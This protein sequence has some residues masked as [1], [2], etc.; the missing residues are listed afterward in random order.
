MLYSNLELKA[1]NT[2]AYFTN[3]INDL[4]RAIMRYLNLK[5]PEGVKLLKLGNV[6]ELKMILLKLKL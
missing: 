5:D 3:S 6:L 2:Q 4:I 1:A